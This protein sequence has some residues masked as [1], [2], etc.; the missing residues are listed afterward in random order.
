MGTATENKIRSESATL[1][2]RPKSILCSAM[3]AQMECTI[4]RYSTHYF[5][6][7]NSV[8]SLETWRSFQIE[9]ENDGNR[10]HETPLAAILDF[11]DRLEAFVQGLQPDDKIA[12]VPASASHKSFAEGRFCLGCYMIICNSMSV[13]EVKVAFQDSTLL[14]EDTNR[15]NSNSSDSSSSVEDRVLNC[16]QAIEQAVSLR[17][18]VAP[19]SDVEPML[20]VEE[21]EHYAG[22]ANGSLH[23]VVPGRMFF[24][25][26]PD[27]LPDGQQWADVIVSS[28]ATTRR[29]SAS[30]H[31]ELFKVEELNVSMVA[32]LG[33]G[34]EAAT[35]AFEARGVEAVDLGLAEDGS[36]LLRGLDRLL[37]L[38][39]AVPGAVAVYSGRGPEWPG[40]LETLV[41]AF[42]IRREGF[43]EGA[44][45]AWLRMVSP[46]KVGGG[47]DGWGPVGAE[48]PAA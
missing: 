10:I 29:F 22:H 36:S 18:L 28:G 16:W 27:D 26:S 2:R 38:S 3:Q 40:Y 43:D 12:I 34:S 4:I 39:R 25:P 42:L 5:K 37:S 7:G 15:T 19:N 41:A 13:D 31:A 48:P 24:F 23:M 32:C 8:E 45:R 6:I 44:A 11:C 35:A 21:L 1:P 17:W 46:G 14:L 9:N 30:F 33:Q 47:D 20:D